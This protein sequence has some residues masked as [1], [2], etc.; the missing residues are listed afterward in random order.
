MPELEVDA[1]VSLLEL[2]PQALAEISLLEPFGHGNPRPLFV[3]RGAQIAG[4]PRLLGEDGRHVS[5]HLRQGRVT[6]RAIAFDKG[7]LYGDLERAASL[8]VLFRPKLSWWQG[9]SQVELEVRE[10]LPG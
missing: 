1:E 6:L 2:T 3:L 4:Q 7:R 9:R 5:F 8:S 10:I